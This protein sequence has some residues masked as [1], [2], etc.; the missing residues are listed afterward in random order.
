MVCPDKYSCCCWVECSI[1]VIYVKLIGDVHIFYIITGFMSV[2]YIRYKERRMHVH[3]HYFEFVNFSF[4]YFSFLLHIFWGYYVEFIHILIVMSSW[5]V[6]CFIIMKCC[7]L[8][9]LIFLFLKS[10]LSDINVSTQALSWLVF[11]GVNFLHTFNLFVFI[12]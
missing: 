6:D 9:Q 8:S 11:V 7:S 1:N 4:Q 10:T 12:L 2:Y 5:W 3:K